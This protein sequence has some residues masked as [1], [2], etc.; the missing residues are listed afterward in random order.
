MKLTK[1]LLIELWINQN[2]SLSLVSSYTGYSQTH[3]SRMAKKFGIKKDKKTIY[4]KI[5]SSRE[6]TFVR[7]Y[8]KVHYMKSREG[9]DQYKESLIKTTGED[10]IAKLE[11]TQ[12]S[13][14]ENCLRKYGVDHTLKL[15]SVRDKQKQTLIENFGS[16]ENFNKEMSKSSSLKCQD[17]NGNTKS[18]YRGK[19]GSFEVR[20]LLEKNILSSLEDYD[21]VGFIEYEKR[22]EIEGRFR[23]PDFHI[24]INGV[25]ILIEAKYHRYVRSQPYKSKS[26]TSK[27]YNMWRNAQ[28]Q[29]NDIKKWCKL[30]D[31]AFLIITEINLNRLHHL[32]KDLLLQHNLS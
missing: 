14:K 3:I 4:Q 5:N 8:G 12:Q 26:W 28:D 22:I 18:S 25:N 32:L 20:S 10:N 13:R 30:N 11:E 23:L 15:K 17:F 21:N 7:K 31:H 24:I 29:I 27:Y 9:Y 1:G 19:F 2:M 16:L 6:K